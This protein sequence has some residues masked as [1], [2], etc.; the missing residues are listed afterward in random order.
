MNLYGKRSGCRGIPVSFIP[1]YSP[2]WLIVCF[3]KAEYAKPLGTPANKR[4]ICRG[5]SNTRGQAAI[6]LQTRIRESRHEDKEKD[7][8]VYQG[9]SIHVGIRLRASE[10]LL[11]VALTHRAE[12][13]IQACFWKICVVFF[14]TRQAFVIDY[15]GMVGRWCSEMIV[16]MTSWY[17]GETANQGILFPLICLGICF[18]LVTYSSSQR[19]CCGSLGS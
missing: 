5:S 12:D 17:Q 2:L 11:E 1:P 6:N 4:A 8:V 3:R 14:V 9:C 7:K 13:G 19:P 16:S 18:S 10:R 15:L